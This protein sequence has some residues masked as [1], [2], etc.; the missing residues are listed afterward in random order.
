MYVIALSMTNNFKFSVSDIFAFNIIAIRFLRQFSPEYSSLLNIN[1]LSGKH[2]NDKPVLSMLKILLIE[3]FVKISERFL[4]KF[5]STEV[6]F[7]QIVR[8]TTSCLL[9]Y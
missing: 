9:H 1:V 4:I 7:P 5:E 3:K 2:L 8:K 6:L